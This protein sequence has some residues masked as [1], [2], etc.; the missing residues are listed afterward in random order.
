MYRTYTLYLGLYYLKFWLIRLSNNSL[1]TGIMLL[2]KNLPRILSKMYENL[3]ERKWEIKKNNTRKEKSRLEVM[4]CNVFAIKRRSRQYYSKNYF[5]ASFGKV[6]KNLKL[7]FCNQKIIKLFFILSPSF[8]KKITI[9]FILKMRQI[10]H[11]SL[12]MKI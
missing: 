8:W 5:W 12:F 10:W 7:F 11:L 2:F 4:N 1:A 9:H 6:T 3:R